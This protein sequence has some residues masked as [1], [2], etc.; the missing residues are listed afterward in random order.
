MKMPGY[1]FVLLISLIS[2]P[3]AAIAS[4]PAKGEFTA[5]KDCPAYQSMRKETNPDNAT[6]TVNRRYRVFE[7]NDPRNVTWYRIA[8]DNATPRDRW[9]RAECGSADVSIGDGRWSEKASASAPAGS[10]QTAGEE[11]SFVFAVSWEPAFCEGHQSEPE[12]RVKDPNSYQARHF[13]LHGLW[14]N[15]AACGIDYGFCGKYKTALQ[16]FCAFDP[17][18]MSEET[19]KKLGVVMPSA[20]YGSCLQRHEWYK[21]GTCQTEWDADGYFGHAMRL[22][23][24]FNG[25]DATG[26]AAFMVRNLGHRVSVLALDSAIDQQFGR[27]AH[28]RMQYICTRDH[29]LESIYINLPAQLGNAPL[30]DLI[31]R[32]AEK[33]GNKCGRSF[34]VDPIN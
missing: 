20:A 8:M 28:K 17:V 13:T 12:C 5:A 18:P 34:V 4:T 10:C 16:P 15:K 1:F 24:D 11:N 2:L 31:R 3:G 14:P 32:G 21:H 19:R 29:K 26:M 9:V 30:D 6:L 33:Y 27:G 22:L 7:V 25:T 23:A